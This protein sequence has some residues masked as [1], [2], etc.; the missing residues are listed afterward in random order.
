MRFQFRSSS[1]L[2]IG[3]WDALKQAGHRASTTGAAAVLQIGSNSR[4]ATAPVRPHG[5]C[6]R[7]GLGPMAAG[8]AEAIQA[9]LAGI[10]EP[11]AAVIGDAF[12]QAPDLLDRPL[13]AARC[14]IHET[15]IIAQTRSSM[16]IVDQHAAH[17]R[18]VYERMKRMLAD[19]GVTR[20]GLLIPEIVEVSEDEAEAL[21][22]RS[23]EL[24]ELGLVLE[25]FGPKA[26][27]VRETPALLGQTDVK[28]LVRDLLLK[29]CVR[30]AAGAQGG[31]SSVRHNGLPAACVLGGASRQTMNAAEW[32][33]PVCRSVQPRPPDACGAAT[34]RHRAAFRPR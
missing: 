32:R 3:A 13:G 23:E 12:A 15:Y 30:R 11:S 26:V 19:G 6:G 29:S 7:Q 22:E 16:I 2:L 27:A 18:L 31:S 34:Q 21:A 4:S 33:H 9:P 5:S 28:G 20:Q 24:A 8:F 17:E 14:Q 10:D 1:L 25:R